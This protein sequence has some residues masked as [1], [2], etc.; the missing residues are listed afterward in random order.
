MKAIRNINGISGC[1][2]H[3]LNTGHAYRSINDA[4]KALKTE[5]ENI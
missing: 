5:R 2:V 3:I 4:L 1:Y